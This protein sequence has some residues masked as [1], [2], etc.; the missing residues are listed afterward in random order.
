LKLSD[1]V[2]ATTNNQVIENLHIVA[3]GKPGIRVKDFTGVVIRNVFIEHRGDA[4]ISFAN[5]NNISIENAVIVHTGAPASGANPSSSLNNISGVNSEAP[6]VRNV[7]LHRGSSGIF[8]D[9]CPGAHLSFIEGYDFRGPFPR[10]QVAQLSGSSDSTLED[11]SV[12]NNE[13]SWTEDN[14]NVHWSS[15]VTVRRGYID[16]N[17][18][19]SGVGVIFDGAG[20]GV[21]STGSVEDVD[22]V[23]MGNGCFSSIRGGAGNVFRRTGCREN[24]CVGQSGR[25][26]PRSEGLMWAA[27]KDGPK[28]RVEQSRYYA[29]CNPKNIYWHQD[30]FEVADIKAVD[31]TPRAA[32]KQRFCWE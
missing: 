31:F 26:A 5:A 21:A 10:G 28:I 22:A 23:R 2:E 30:S 9:R 27:A 11:F 32:L 19:P 16:G 3:T 8:F 13:N 17:N 20:T 29:A 14:V 15:N 4:G 24:I 12:I 18:S 25:E 1:P 7:R 6:K